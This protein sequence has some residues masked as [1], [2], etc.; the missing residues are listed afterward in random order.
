[1]EFVSLYQFWKWVTISTGSVEKD[2]ESLVA[3]IKS[4]DIQLLNVNQRIIFGL[5]YD[6]IHR[7]YQEYIVSR[8]EN[9][10]NAS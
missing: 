8:I 5:Y 6:A 2:F 10:L 9:E 7:L 3:Y 1:M 4:D